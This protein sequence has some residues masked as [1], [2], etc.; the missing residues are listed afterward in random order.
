MKKLILKL[1]KI[2]TNSIEFREGFNKI[3][4]NIDSLTQEEQI[5]FAEL[6]QKFIDEDVEKEKGKSK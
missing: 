5:L 4:D 1:G 2:P 3:L 6:A